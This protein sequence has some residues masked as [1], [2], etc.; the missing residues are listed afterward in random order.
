MDGRCSWKAVLC[1]KESQSR[2]AADESTKSS[3]AQLNGV[4]LKDQLHR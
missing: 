3:H 1:S 2:E 4:S